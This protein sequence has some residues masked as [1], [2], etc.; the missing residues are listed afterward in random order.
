[1]LIQYKAREK[2]SKLDQMCH[3][4]KTENPIMRSCI[5]MKIT[6]IAMSNPQMQDLSR[7]WLGFYFP[8]TDAHATLADLMSIRVSIWA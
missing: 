8:I 5:G 6:G 1:M 3:P 2:N 4:Q 7:Q